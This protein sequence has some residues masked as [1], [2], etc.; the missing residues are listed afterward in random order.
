[1]IT[2]SNK[3]SN[4]VAFLNNSLPFYIKDKADKAVGFMLHFRWLVLGHTLYF[5]A[6][7]LLDAVSKAFRG[8]AEL[9][10]S[11]TV[12]HLHGLF[13]QKKCTKD[14]S[15]SQSHFLSLACTNKGMAQND[16]WSL[17]SERSLFKDFPAGFG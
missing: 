4:R 17:E 3:N 6:L 15:H 8:T 16:H 9:V 2:N 5:L 11:H 14:M 1:M 7:H 10:L 13:D 12:T